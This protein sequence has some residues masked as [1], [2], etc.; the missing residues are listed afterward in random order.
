MSTQSSPSQEPQKWFLLIGIDFYMAGNQRYDDHRRPLSFRSLGGCVQDVREMREYIETELKVDPSHI[1]QLTST[2]ASDGKQSPL[3]DISD[4]PTYKNIVRLFKKVTDNANA[5]DLVYIHYSGHGA[6]VKTSYENLK[7]LNGHDEALVPLD[8]ECGGQY[9]LDVELAILLDAM[10]KKGLIVTAVLD[11][12]YS[13]GATRENGTAVSR[14]TNRPELMDSLKKSFRRVD[15]E[16][17]LDPQGYELL[18][19]CRSNEEANEDFFEGHN[20]PHGILTHTLLSSLRLGGSNL[21]HGILFQRIQVKVNELFRDQTPVFAG[22]RQRYIFSSHEAEYIQSY[23]IKRVQRNKLTFGAGIPHGI[24]V[25]S[26]YAIYPWNVQNFND[27]SR[28]PRARVVKV[29]HLESTAE[30]L[31]PDPSP[32]SVKIEPGFHAV[33]LKSMLPKLPVKFLDDRSSNST[34]RFQLNRLQDEINR[35]S[36]DCPVE[37]ISEAETQAKYHISV[38][39]SNNFKL[40]NS[41]N[42]PIRNFPQLNDPKSFIHSLIHLARYDFLLGLTHSAQ[43]LKG[44]FSFEV[45]GICLDASTD[46]YRVTN[47]TNI[48]LRFTNNCGMPLNITIFDFMPSWGIVK[49]FPDDMDYETVTDGES[50]LESRYEFVDCFKIFITKEPTSFTS[51]ELPELGPHI[52]RWGS[53]FTRGENDLEILLAELGVSDRHSRLVRSSKKGGEWATAEVEVHIV[54]RGEHNAS[55]GEDISEGEEFF[56]CE[57]FIE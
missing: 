24:T 57:E 10:V 36:Q 56:D 8:I 23:P 42:K 45:D 29:D 43:S 53:G 5:G 50:R 14:G 48:T 18:A 13:G 26:E 44:K 39:I 22:N 9:L 20:H 33:L 3:E 1:H 7:G 25:G 32:S 46:S 28:R 49:L 17:W 30:L 12:C 51:L 11:S 19:A 37:V 38:D 6:R 15:R 52:A 31:F 41:T 21:T 55:I 40:F 34:G 47:E 54:P 16:F 4:L 35:S 27:S 2:K